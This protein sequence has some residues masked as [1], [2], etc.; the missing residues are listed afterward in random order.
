LRVAAS[1]LVVVFGAGGVGRTVA[2]D[3][4][5][6]HDVS[7]RLVDREAAALEAARRIAPVETVRA[8]LA[9]A[10]QMARCLGGARA[11][12]LALPGSLGRAALRAAIEA[13]V[14]VADVCFSPGDPFDFDEAARN[15]RLAAVVDCGVAPGISN[16]L[17]GR[18][19][20]ELDQVDSAEIFVG[21]LPAVRSWPW[22]YRVVFSLPDVIEEYTRP[23]R[24]REHGVEVTKPA[25]SDVEL[26]DIPGIGTLEAF[27]TDGLRT[28][29]RTIP[30]RTLREKTLRYPGHAERIRVLRESGFFQTEP[31]RVGTQDVAPRELTT[32]LLG[33]LWQLREG[34]EEFTILRV[35][36][37]GR[38]AGRRVRIAWEL[39]DRTDPR[40]GTTSMCRTTG[41][42]CAIVA[43]L[44]SRGEIPFTGIVPM[45]RLGREESL[46]RRILDG[47][48]QRSVRI[49]R[50]ETELGAPE[51]K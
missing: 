39:F 45:E 28:L 17:V 19:A 35:V 21:G 20:A 34:E 4:A 13:G 40:T 11:A 15:A 32:A 48:A 10:G 37:E 14:P 18:S 9:S 38:K 42:P 23:C 1:N 12:V 50:E 22:E 31:V 43:R 24:M 36:V 47:L 2:R 27:N 5:E 6:E 49:R 25:L 16:L 8:D 44:L 30:A 41:F 29:L 33:R 7:V 46:A 51:L 3:L 26:V